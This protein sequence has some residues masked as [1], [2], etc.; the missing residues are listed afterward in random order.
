MKDFRALHRKAPSLASQMS[1]VHR[2]V[3]MIIRRW[4]ALTGGNARHAAS[5]CSFDDLAREAEAS[6]AP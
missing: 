4:Q 1:I 5:G 3:D 2:P 6:N